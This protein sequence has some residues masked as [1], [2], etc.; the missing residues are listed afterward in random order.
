MSAAQPLIGFTPATFIRSEPSLL[1]PLRV[2]SRKLRLDLRTPPGANP[3]APFFARKAYF[4][5]GPATTWQELYRTWFGD[6]ALPVANYRFWFGASRELDARIRRAYEPLW[7]EAVN[8]GLKD[9]EEHPK[10]CLAKLILID[11]LS[12]NMFRCTADAFRHDA[13]GVR[14]ANRCAEFIADGFVYHFEDALIMAWPWLHMEQREGVLRAQWWCYGLTEI[15]RGTPFH[16]RMVMHQYGFDRHVRCIDRFGRYPHRNVVLGRKD[17]P[18]EQAYL[19]DEAE[20]WERDQTE[21]ARGGTLRYKLGELAFFARTSMYYISTRNA[22][23][24]WQMIKDSL[25]ATVGR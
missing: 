25:R 9:W 5:E 21:Q 1:P 11:Q 23:L 10:A 13:L 19:R 16:G 7:R 15:S 20:M 24:G 3:A 22:H 18:E 6:H 4:P 12:R 8:G 17:T 14:L 2:D